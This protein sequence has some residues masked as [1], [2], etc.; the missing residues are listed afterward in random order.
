MVSVD[1][2]VFGVVICAVVIR[3]VFEIRCGRFS[4]G[5]FLRSCHLIVL[6]FQIDFLSLVG[7]VICSGFIRFFMGS[8]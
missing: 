3:T 8:N 6:I 4:C 1:V 7:V 5:V 2:I